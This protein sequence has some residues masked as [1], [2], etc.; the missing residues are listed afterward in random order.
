MGRRLTTPSMND[1][2]KKIRFQALRELDL[3]RTVGFSDK[4]IRENFINRVIYL[5]GDELLII[6]QYEDGEDF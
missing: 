1:I 4:E 5:S 3:L 2:R 6:E